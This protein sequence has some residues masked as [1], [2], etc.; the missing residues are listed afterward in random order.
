MLFFSLQAVLVAGFFEVESVRAS[1]VDWLWLPFAFAP[2][3]RASRASYPYKSL[4]RCVFIYN[5]YEYVCVITCMNMHM[6]IYIFV[7]MRPGIMHSHGSVH[8]Q[9]GLLRFFPLRY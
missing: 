3:P 8:M 7:R 6:L 1:A 4:C 9:V 5:I 2:Q